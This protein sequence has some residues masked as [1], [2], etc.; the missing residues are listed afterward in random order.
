MEILFDLNF[1]VQKDDVLVICRTVMI[2]LSHLEYTLYGA[3]VESLHLFISIS[4]AVPEHGGLLLLIV[5]VK[6]LFL[7]L[8]NHQLMGLDSHVRTRNLFLQH[9]RQ[10]ARRQAR[11]PEGRPFAANL[12]LTREFP[13]GRS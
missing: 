11:F 8:L 9:I 6:C 1:V 3:F 4:Q 5:T 10:V 12:L 2:F 7:L 13:Q